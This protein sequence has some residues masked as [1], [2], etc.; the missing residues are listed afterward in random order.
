MMTDIS[1]M[2]VMCETTY[3]LIAAQASP[4][5]APVTKGVDVEIGRVGDG[6]T[7]LPPIPVFP[8]VPVVPVTVVVRA[9]ALLIH[10]VDYR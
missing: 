5:V 7:G 9:Q 6:P 4:L 2:Q 10:D 8:I 3:A 1:H